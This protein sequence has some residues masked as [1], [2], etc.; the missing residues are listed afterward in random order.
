[1]LPSMTDDPR[2]FSEEHHAFRTQ[3]RRFVEQEIVPHVDEWE[4]AG[5]F[6]SELFAEL[7]KHGFLGGSYPEEHGGLGGDYFYAVVLAEELAR[8]RSGGVSMGVLAHCHMGLPIVSKLGSPELIDEVVRPALAGEKIVSICV[9]EPDAGSD[10]AGIKTTARR[11]GDDYIVNGSKMYITN[12]TRADYLTMAVKTDPE[13]GHK[14][15]SF[16]V[17]PT[18]GT[19]GFHVSKALKKLGMKSS[20]TAVLAF[21]DC[22]IPKRYLLGEENRGFP[23]IMQNFQGERLIAAVMSN[24]RARHSMEDTWAYMGERHIFGKPQREFQVLRHLFAD[25]TARL[26]AS[27]AFAYD[28]TQKFTAAPT[29]PTKLIS[30]AKMYATEMNQ[31]VTDRCLQIHG[32][33]GYID[34][35]PISRSWRDGRLSTIGGGATEVMREIIAKELAREWMK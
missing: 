14:G 2:Y 6:P 11:D 1:M 18:K 30:M 10:V 3:L 32:G 22:R 34:E 15:M 13:A 5:M 9:S 26:L 24:M 20:D 33:M 4:E 35:T 27:E 23:Y 16:I 19:K 29:P 8:C 12:G 17:F 7:G 28:V 21:E 25:M 31:W